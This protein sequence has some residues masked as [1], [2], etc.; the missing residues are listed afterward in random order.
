MGKEKALSNLGFF[1]GIIGTVIA[2]L[3]FF[4]MKDPQIF[5]ILLPA[6]LGI[7][8]LFIVLR[9]KKVLNDDVIKVGLIVNPLA[10]ILGIT[11]AVIYFI[12]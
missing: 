6:I 5:N 10:I 7:G 11:Q 1:L 3:P 4:N 9:V 8:G 12:K 2:L